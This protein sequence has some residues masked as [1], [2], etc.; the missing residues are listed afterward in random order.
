MSKLQDKYQGLLGYKP[1]KPVTHSLAIQD[2][3]NFQ[4]RQSALDQMA[5]Q[6]DMSNSAHQREVKDLLAAGLNPVLSANNGASVTSGASYTADS[7]SAVS[8]INQKLQ[9]QT[10]KQIA[11][12]NNKMS[13]KINQASL[14]VQ[15]RIAKY[16]AD[17]GYQAALYGAD[18]SAAAMMYSANQ[19]AGASMYG[20]DLTYSGQ[21][22]GLKNQFKMA[23]QQNF[24]SFY[25]N[26]MNMYKSPIS[27]LSMS[28]NWKQLRKT[29]TNQSLKKLSI[30]E[31]AYYLYYGHFPKSAKDKLVKK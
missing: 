31:S 24:N 6:R 19:S 29:Y 21:M 1:T 23:D 20:A 25:Q 17:L 11:D 27:A 7:A 13:W 26:C 28:S 16:Q 15:E 18:Q 2:Y 8:S 3:Y 12:K 9:N 10:S 30:R 4:T 5:F 14:K 22:Q